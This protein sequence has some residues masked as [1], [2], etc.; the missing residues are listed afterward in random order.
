MVSRCGGRKRTPGTREPVPIPAA[1]AA[2]RS[3]FRT[4]SNRG[5]A[6]AA[7]AL[8]CRPTSRAQRRLGLD[9]QTC[10][11][12]AGA[13]AVG[14]SNIPGSPGRDSGAQQATTLTARPPRLVSL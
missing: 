3:F 7:A 14:A 2:R 5:A 9:D 8:S 11:A 13:S 1:P 6:R 4:F 10:D 12:A